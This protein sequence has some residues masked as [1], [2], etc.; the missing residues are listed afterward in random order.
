MDINWDA[1]KVLFDVFQAA[2]LAAMAIYVWWTSRSRASA[3][4]IRAVDK[5]VD[6]LEA[7]LKRRPGFNDLDK[8]RDELHLITSRM[9]EIATQMQATNSLLDRLH[10]YMLNG[11]GNK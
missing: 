2:V 8:L 10:D 5:R 4:A 6:Q 7:Q 11:R 1:A 9:G 3:A